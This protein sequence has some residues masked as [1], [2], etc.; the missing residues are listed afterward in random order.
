MTHEALPAVLAVAVDRR[1]LEPRKAEELAAEAR[2]TGK[3]PEAL[4]IER[5][6]LSARRVERL[7]LHVR[8]RSLRKVDKAYGRMAVKARVVD[9]ATVSAALD[10]QRRR[11]EDRR[12]CLRIGAILIK[13]GHLTQDE[14]R[15]IRSRVAKLSTGDSASQSAAATL[16]DDSASQGT[17][18]RGLPAVKAPSYEAIDEAVARVAAV[19][20]EQAELSESVSQRAEAVT[21]DSAAEYENACVV[22]ARRRVAGGGKPVSKSTGNLRIGA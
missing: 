11:F 8:Y 3:V 6:L 5:G 12:E 10:L 1:Y 13:Q 17:P 2:R 18:R 15:H 22:L 19:R 21:R 4:L 20:K 9:E 7:V 14:D 16:L